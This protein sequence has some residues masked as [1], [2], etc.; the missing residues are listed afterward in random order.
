MPYEE[1]REVRMAK[2]DI[3]SRKV[4]RES[5]SAFALTPFSSKLARMTVRVLGPLFSSILVP[6]VPL[7]N[8]PCRVSE[9]ALHS[10]D[11]HSNRV[12]GF[13][14]FQSSLASRKRL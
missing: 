9:L 11:N 2:A 13:D 12:L 3:L 8:P 7:H 4:S 14:K 1:W 5:L 10:V 6:R